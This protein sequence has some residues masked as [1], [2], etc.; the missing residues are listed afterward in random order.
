MKKIFISGTVSEYVEKIGEINEDHPTGVTNKYSQAK[1]EILREVERMNPNSADLIWGRIFHTYGAGQPSHTLY[2]SFQEAVN[3]GIAEFQ[4]NNFNVAHDF[5]HINEVAKKVL[6][7]TFHSDSRG[8]FN[9]ASGRPTR[10]GDLVQ[11]WAA[12][13]SSKI[14]VVSAPNS[15]QSNSYWAGTAK[16]ERLIG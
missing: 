11:E 12:A 5:L 14:K 1:L 15:S 10:L 2:G 7:L 8:V 6:D 3:R 4:V 16:A 9:V 13:S